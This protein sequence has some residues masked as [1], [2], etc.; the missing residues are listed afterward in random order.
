M[1]LLWTVMPLGFG[2]A[3]PERGS[4]VFAWPVFVTV[5][6]FG[7]DPEKRICPERSSTGDV[8]D[9]EPDET[10]DD[11]DVESTTIGPFLAVSCV[12]QERVTEV[13]VGARTRIAAGE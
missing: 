7:L 6:L 13:P 10:I 9:G 11:E 12:V 8:T 3:M 2:A 5:A 4:G 1:E